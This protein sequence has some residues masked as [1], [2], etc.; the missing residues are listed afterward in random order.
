MEEIDALARR[1]EDRL[2][3]K[4]GGRTAE[5]AELLALVKMV[6]S[7]AV[8]VDALEAEKARRSEP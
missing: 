4:L 3:G 1:Y 7:L 6:K 8:R 5:T 2:A